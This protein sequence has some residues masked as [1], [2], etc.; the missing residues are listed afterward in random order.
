M[1]ER[2]RG[3]RNSKRYKKEDVREQTWLKYIKRDRHCVLLK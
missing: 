2:E 3:M 1:L